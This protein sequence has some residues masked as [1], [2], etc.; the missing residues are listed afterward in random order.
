M[1]ESFAYCASSKSTFSLAVVRD[2]V[3]SQ[4]RCRISG[5]AFLGVLVLRACGALRSHSYDILQA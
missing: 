5:G 1:L 4:T 2:A 3:T